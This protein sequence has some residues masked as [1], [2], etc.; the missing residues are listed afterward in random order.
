VT[1]NWIE[2]VIGALVL[3]SPWILG[4]S[5]IS[6][7]RWLNVLC[8]MVL[9]VMNVWMIYGNDP[10]ARSAATVAEDASQQ[11]QKRVRRVV[12]TASASRKKK[13]EQPLMNS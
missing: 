1:E 8:G 9:V 2:L 4:F 3:I 13:V 12:N 5:D 11:K 6:L 7:A 10:A